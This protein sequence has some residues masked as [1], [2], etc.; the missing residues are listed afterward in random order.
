MARGLRTITLLLVLSAVFWFDAAAVA[1]QSEGGWRGKATGR[2]EVEIAAWRRWVERYRDLG[3]RVWHRS[4]NSSRGGDASRATQPYCPP[5]LYTFGK[6]REVIFECDGAGGTE[7]APWFESAEL[8]ESESG[9]EPRREVISISREDVQSLIVHSGTVMVQPDQP[10]VLVNTDTVV[11]TDATEHVLS[12]QVLGLDVDVRVSPALYTWD[13]G[14]GSPPLTTT[15]PGRAWPDHTVSHVYRA[16]TTATI[17]L[18]TE[19]DAVF[20]VEGTDV[21]V[22]VTGRAVTTA[23]TDPIDVVTATPRLTSG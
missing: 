13:F 23:A 21:W 1:E 2:D 8:D 15:D 3:E 18:R 14:D 10:W 9:E 20:R 12:T 19:W 4:T 7:F 6:F 22:P 5:T 11:M 17:S 16:P